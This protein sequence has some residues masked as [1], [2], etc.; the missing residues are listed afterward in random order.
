MAS[1]DGQWF[2]GFDPK[3]EEL[4]LSRW[5][6]QQVTKS[7]PAREVAAV[8]YCEANKSWWWNDRYSL[9][10]WESESPD[11]PQQMIDMS[12]LPNRI[13]SSPDGRFIA[14]ADSYGACYVWDDGGKRITNLKFPHNHPV[15]DLSFS[16]S[17]QT[18]MT[19]TEYGVLR[20][21]NLESGRCTYAEKNQE[22]QQKRFGGFL[23][24]GRWLMRIP[25]RVDTGEITIERLSDV[26]R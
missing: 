2:A 8:H 19:L 3:T 15:I 1:A 18:L 13:V 16:A 24:G 21:W 14:V 26:G 6:S 20:C 22:P 7:F 9:F 23:E 12:S 5:G 10:R 25:L 17:S 4:W 11:G